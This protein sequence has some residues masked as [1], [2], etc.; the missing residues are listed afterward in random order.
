VSSRTTYTIFSP[1]VLSTQ[2][3]NFLLFLI[4]YFGRFVVEKSIFAHP[5]PRFQ[6]LVF[7]PAFY[8][9]RQPT[10]AISTTPFVYSATKIKKNTRLRQSFGNGHCQAEENCRAKLI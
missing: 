1:C 5:L 7:Q 8:H 9:H 4:G 6:G 10:T 3:V 2:C